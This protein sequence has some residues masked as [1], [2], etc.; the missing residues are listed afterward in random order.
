MGD[1]EIDFVDSSFNNSI[2]SSVN[3]SNLQTVKSPNCKISQLH[4]KKF[5]F[6]PLIHSILD[7][8]YKHNQ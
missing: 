3:G 7:Q 8:I 1:L 4:K 6:T 2:N 5:C